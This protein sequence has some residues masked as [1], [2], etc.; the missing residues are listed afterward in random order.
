MNS[1]HFTGQ[2]NVERKV[3]GLTV[4]SGSGVVSDKGIGAT[5]Q[6]CFWL[7]GNTATTSAPA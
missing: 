7:F 5:T 2:G 1:Q 6:V 3:L 4:G